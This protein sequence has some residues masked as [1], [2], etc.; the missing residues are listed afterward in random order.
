MILHN[1]W[2]WAKEGKPVLFEKTE[3]YI[4]VFDFSHSS[5]ENTVNIKDCRQ[6]LGYK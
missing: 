5:Y 6:N 1:G 4:T 3:P 2:S